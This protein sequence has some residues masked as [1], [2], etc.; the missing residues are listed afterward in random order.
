[1]SLSQRIAGIFLGIT[2]ATVGGFLLSTVLGNFISA[3]ETANHQVETVG[4]VV[5]LRKQKVWQPGRR[6]TVW[7]QNKYITKQCPVFQFQPQTGKPVQSMDCFLTPL[8]VGDSVYVTYDSR[9]PGSARASGIMYSTEHNQAV[10]FSG[11]PVAGASF[12]ILLG[13]GR[14]LFDVI[15][16]IND[17]RLAK[18]KLSDEFKD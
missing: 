9:N 5:A 1:M 10:F 6:S 4:K 16:L 15:G 2:T 14:T 13:V 8:Q 17:R 11:I 12:I 7:Q 3:V 18:Q